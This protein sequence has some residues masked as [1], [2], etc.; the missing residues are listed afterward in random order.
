[1]LYFDTSF[2]APL[3]LPEPTSEEISDFVHTLPVEKLAMSH[4]A[5]IEFS[6]LLAREVR[7]GG[8]GPEIAA[9][10]DAQFETTVAESFHI[11]LPNL[12]D[13]DLGKTLLRD[14]AS[15]LRGGDALHLAIA[16]NHGA[17]AVYSLDKKMVKAGK[18]LGLAMNTGI[19]LPGYGD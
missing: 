12:R 4:W 19:R 10:A 14:H 2:L 5:R 3:I 17:E 16:G 9:K 13:F 11:I 8:L 6:S 7:M 1:M 18:A 15:G